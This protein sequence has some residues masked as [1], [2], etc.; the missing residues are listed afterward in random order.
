MKSS[1]GKVNRM[2]VSPD[3]SYTL[4]SLFENPDDGIYAITKKIDD[5][6]SIQM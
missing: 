1:D 5:A 2:N 3:I 6:L 4:D